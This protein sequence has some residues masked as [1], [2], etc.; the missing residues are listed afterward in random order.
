MKLYLVHHAHAMTAEQDPARPLSEQG[1][2]EADR[3]GDRL[4][5]YG[6]APVRI[7]HS[8]KLWTQQTAERIGDKLGLRDRVALAPYGIGTGD[9]L[10]PFMKEIENAGGDLMM[11]GHV[12]YLVRSAA[13]L[14]CGDEGRMGVEFKPGNG[15]VFCLE[16]SGNCWAVT[17]GWRQD[18][19][20]A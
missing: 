12:D 2:I 13:R 7:L 8:E 1:R 16:G 18:Q 5:A 11:A 19:L 3:L 17:W 6:A 4:K 15:T 10:T 14:I 20:A 9:D